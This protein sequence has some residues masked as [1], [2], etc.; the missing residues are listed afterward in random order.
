MSSGTYLAGDSHAEG[1][2]SVVP[3]VGSDYERGRQTRAQ[4]P[5]P[6]ELALVVVALGTNDYDRSALEAEVRALALTRGGLPLVWVLPPH[7]TRP[8]LAARRDAVVA[9]IRAGLRGVA[10]ALELDPPVVEL[11]GDGAHPT[12]A[13]YREIAE[14]IAGVGSGG[15]GLGFLLFAGAALAIWRWFH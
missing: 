13:G 5:L 10:G 8:D 1:L 4:P 15:G 12:H 7:A 3:H 14:A 6:L 2:A 11:G 9:H